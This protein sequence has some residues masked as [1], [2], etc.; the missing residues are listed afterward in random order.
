[1]KPIFN[2]RQNRRYHI[3]TG[4]SEGFDIWESRSPA[5]NAFIFAIHKDNIFVLAEKRSEIM[6]EGPGLWVAPCGYM[7]WNENGWD[8]LRREVYEETSFYIDEYKKY[9]IFNN[10]KEP[11][12]TITDVN[13]NR[14]NVVLCYCV[15]FDF[16]EIDL[17]REIENYKYKEIEK[18]EWIPI[19][20]VLTPNYLWGFDHNK[21]IEE[22]I[23]KF[24]KY[25]IQ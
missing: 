9:M 22:A 14:Q 17:P 11:Y 18:I 24:E 7:D 21:R 13:E 4:I 8:A 23:I 12:Y 6:P 20:R 3:N 1:M 10:D 19:E 15:I 25:L 5:I 2:N 16:S